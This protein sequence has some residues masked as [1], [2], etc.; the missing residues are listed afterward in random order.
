MKIGIIGCGFVGSAVSVG[1]RDIYQIIVDPV[2]SRNTIKDMVDANV[3][4]AFV[5]VPTPFDE[6]K[7]S[8]DGSYVLDVIQD[9]DAAKFKGVVAL[10]STITPNFLRIIK[11]NYNLRLVYNPEFL[12]QKNAEHDFMFPAMTILGGNFKDTRVLSDLYTRYSWVD[13][14]APIFVTSIETA[15]MIKYTINSWLATKVAFFNELYALNEVTG[16]IDNWDEFT[17]IVGHDPRIGKS[18][19]RVPGDGDEFGFGG[20]CFPKDTNALAHYARNSQGDILSIL[21]AAMTSNILNKEKR[22]V[23]E[24]QQ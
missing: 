5:C 9:L 1:F 6:D 10:K 19:M 4:V 24:D 14:T 12:T 7:A 11:S 15:S 2:K 16:D 21:E 18:H 3:D 20:A 17:A 13:I 23:S 22:S 8:V